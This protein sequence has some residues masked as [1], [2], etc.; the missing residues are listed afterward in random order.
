MCPKKINMARFDTPVKFTFKPY[1]LLEWIVG[2]RQFPAMMKLHQENGEVQ[3]AAFLYAMG[4][5]DAN[6]IFH[7]LSFVSPKVDTDYAITKHNNTVDRFNVI[8]TEDQ[9][10]LIFLAHADSSG[11]S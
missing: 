5:R 9:N 3:R 2:I 10:A 4:G 6:R 1:E 11:A 7:T 8:F